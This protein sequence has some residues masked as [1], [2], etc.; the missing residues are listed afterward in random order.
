MFLLF[1][2]DAYQVRRHPSLSNRARAADG[3]NIIKGEQ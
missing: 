1:L 3:A 2:A